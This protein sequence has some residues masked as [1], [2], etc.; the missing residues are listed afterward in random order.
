MRRLPLLFALLLLS[1]PASA[2]GQAAPQSPWTQ[3]SIEELLDTD[4][5]T[6]ARRPDSIRRAAA[7]VQVLTGE[8]LHRAGIRYLSEALRLADAFYVGRFDGRTWVVNTRGLNINGANKL[9]VMIDGRTEEI[10]Y[11]ILEAGDALQVQQGQFIV[12][13]WMVVEPH[14]VA[15]V[16]DQRFI[17]DRSE[18][19][20]T[21]T[22][23]D[24]FEI[25]DA[26]GTILILAPK[27]TNAP[28]SEY[29]RARLVP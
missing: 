27:P 25:Q 28:P 20:D 22:E 1:V 17:L 15:D 18:F 29:L 11:L 7:A 3:L 16:P 23:L 19:L 4:V 12:V 24:Q 26:A 2:D 14:F 6:A 8:D 10:R 13:P 9:Q 21:W 5:T